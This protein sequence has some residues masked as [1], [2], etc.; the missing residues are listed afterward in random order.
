[1][2]DSTISRYPFPWAFTWAEEAQALF[3]QDF[4]PYGVRANRPTLEAFLT[5]C[6]EQGVAHRPV[7]LEELFAPCGDD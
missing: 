2:R 5:Y 6:T 7:T 4:W 3:G 1:M